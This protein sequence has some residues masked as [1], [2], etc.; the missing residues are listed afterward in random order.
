MTWG[1]RIIEALT[2]KIIIKNILPKTNVTKI[3]QSFSPINLR[4][5]SESQEVI[6]KKQYIVI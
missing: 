6:I 1:G 4:L 2:M 3:L 5:K